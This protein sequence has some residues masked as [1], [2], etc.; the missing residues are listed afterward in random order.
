MRH[1]EPTMRVYIDRFV[2]GL[3][4][5]LHRAARHGSGVRLV[6]GPGRPRRARTT[7]IAA[8]AS[9]APAH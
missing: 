5:D 4:R 9:A 1:E 3:T 2:A 8:D 7:F 6:P